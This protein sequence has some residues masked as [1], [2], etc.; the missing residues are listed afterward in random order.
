MKVFAMCVLCLFPACLLPAADDSRVILL[1]TG[2]AKVSGGARYDDGA[3]YK[4]IRDWRTTNVV[5]RWA[6][7][8]PARGAWRVLL[9]YACPP[10]SAGSAFEVVAGEQ[11]ANGFTRSTGNWTTFKEHDVGPILLRKPG[12]HELVVRVTRQTGGSVWDLRHVKL[13]RED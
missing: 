8:L 12:A 2:E 4:C 1:P 11:R 9:T 7:T 13:A 5:A 10:E 3:A 6:F